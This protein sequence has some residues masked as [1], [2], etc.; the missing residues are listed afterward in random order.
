MTIHET[1]EAAK[2]AGMTY[3]EYV[4][5]HEAPVEPK[6]KEPEEGPSQDPPGIEERTCV[7]CGRPFMVDLG[8]GRK[9][10]QIYC[11]KSCANMAVQARKLERA[12]L[13]VQP[14]VPDPEP[15]MLNPEPTMPNQTAKADAGK[16]RLSLVPPQ[17]LREIAAVREYGTAKYGDDPDNWRSVELDRLWDACLRHITA[18]WDNYTAR[19][20]ES[21]LMH[22]SH[23]AT[24]LAFLMQATKE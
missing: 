10:K 2:A 15:T 16:P 3:G 6:P 23:A 22:I 8:D 4:L 20:P 19:D 5:A 1:N 14:V 11:S 9:K 7:Q 18:A 12:K 17:I 21:G 13:S 24:N